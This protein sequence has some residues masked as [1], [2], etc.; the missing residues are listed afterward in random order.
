MDFNGSRVWIVHCLSDLQ[1]RKSVSAWWRLDEFNGLNLTTSMDW[2]DEIPWTQHSIQCLDELTATINSWL[3]FDACQPSK[4]RRW[5]WVYPVANWNSCGSGLSP[6]SARSSRMTR[7]WRSKLLADTG[8]VASLSFFWLA[9]LEWKFN[10]SMDFRALMYSGGFTLVVDLL[11]GPCCAKPPKWPDST[12]AL[13]LPVALLLLA[14]GSP[15]A[16]YY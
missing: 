13:L 15:V 8:T 9:D 6:R 10:V 1:W 5:T 12:M 3:K 16:Y 7:Q 14:F 4:A 2:L 11:R